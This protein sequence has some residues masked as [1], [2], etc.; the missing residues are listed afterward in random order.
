MFLQVQGLTDELERRE[1]YKQVL[2]Q[3]LQQPDLPQAEAACCIQDIQLLDAHIAQICGALQAP[4]QQVDELTG[5]NNYINTYVTNPMDIKNLQQ[6]QAKLD[7][8]IQTHVKR[9]LE[10]E[11]QE[12]QRQAQLLQ[13]QAQQQQVQVPLAVQQPMLIPRGG[14]D[15]AG[16]SIPDLPQLQTHGMPVADDAPL[17]DFSAMFK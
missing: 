6:L 7:A 3:K 12:Q 5:Q 11:L 4:R 8:E 2:Q 9:V 15:T 17:P 10:T 16:A 1:E 14:N 13:Q